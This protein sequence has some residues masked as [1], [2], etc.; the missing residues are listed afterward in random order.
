MES[1]ISEV[2]DSPSPNKAGAQKVRNLR[3]RDIYQKFVLIGNRFCVILKI[4]FSQK[5]SIQHK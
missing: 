2:K 1:E 4:Q 5:Y 3:S